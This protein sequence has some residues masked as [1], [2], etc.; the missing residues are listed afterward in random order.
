MRV[1]SRLKWDHLAAAGMVAVSVVFLSLCAKTKVNMYPVPFTLQTF[2]VYF[3][4]LRTSPRDSF[5]SLLGYISVGLLGVPVF[6][7]AT[8]GLHAVMA[9]PS[10]GYIVGMLFAAPAI[11]FARRKG[12][13]RFVACVIGYA[14]VHISGILWLRQFFDVK[15]SITYGL[16]PFVMVDFLKIS[17]ALAV[18]TSYDVFK[19]FRSKRE[20]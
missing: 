13:N 3:I 7:P 10:F 20:K 18:S 19:N 5:L 9:M 15:A 6:S 4:A 12:V 14:I 1:V 11:S 16:F 17:V 8:A 2:A